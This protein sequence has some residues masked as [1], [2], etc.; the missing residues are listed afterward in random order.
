MLRKLDRGMLSCPQHQLPRLGNHRKGA[1][2]AGNRKL[3]SRVT[4]TRKN[5]YKVQGLKTPVDRSNPNAAVAVEDPYDLVTLSNLCVDVLV[6]CD[7]IPPKDENIRKELL[8]RLSRDPPVASSWEVGGNT[9]T[10]IAGCRLGMHVASIGHI[11]QDVFG[12]FLK[13][14]L[15]EE[16]IHLPASVVEEKEMEKHDT[17]V[18]FVLVDHESSEHGFCSKYDFG[19][20][21]LFAGVSSLPEEALHVLENTK[22]VFINGFVFDEIPEQVVVDAAL[23]AQEH[24]AVV[25]F[26]PGPRSWTFKNGPRRHALESML[27]VADIILMTEEEAGVVVGS[28]DAET[29]LMLLMDRPSTKAKWFIIKMGAR[30]ALLGDKETRTLYHQEG[31]EVDVKDTV[32]CGDSFAAAVALGYTM[33]RDTVHTLALAG[34]V[35]AATATGIGA[36]RNVATIE[37]VREILYAHSTQDEQSLKRVSG[38]LSILKDHVPF[39]GKSSQ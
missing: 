29:A 14:V 37:K 28:T 34:A 6:A 15:Q 5:T 18:C 11:G 10:L 22:S 26:D 39:Q 4:E 16:G 8:E 1:W 7:K 35:G 23:H 31:Y 2:V 25:L 19:P 9:N 12:Q 20:W 30:G 33:K 27:D 32:G 24:G 38:A 3:D 13:D 21:P 36:G 17:L